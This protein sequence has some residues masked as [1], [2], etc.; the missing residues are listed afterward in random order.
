MHRSGAECVAIF[1]RLWGRSAAVNEHGLGLL[2][3]FVGP[4]FAQFT[5]LLEWFIFR[6]VVFLG[7][8]E[9]ES[10]NG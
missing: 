6:L 2:N 10:G 8:V 5:S 3:R 4:N 9:C 7:E 1:E